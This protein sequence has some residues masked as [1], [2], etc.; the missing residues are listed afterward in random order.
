M[1]LSDDVELEPALNC[2]R[3]PLELIDIEDETI[4]AEILDAMNTVSIMN[5]W[6][7]SSVPDVKWD[8]I[9]G[10][11]E[12]KKRMIELVQYPIDILKYLPN[13]E[14]NVNLHLDVHYGKGTSIQGLSLMN[15]DQLQV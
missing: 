3:E 15:F 5:S 1:K 11:E 7:N 12:R 4:D 9:G 8:D 6:N 13:M 14:H 2:I 10:L